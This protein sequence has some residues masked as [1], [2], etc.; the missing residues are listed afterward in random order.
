MESDWHS[1]KLGDLVDIKHGFALKSENFC[2]E[3][4]NDIL[5]TPGHKDA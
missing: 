5:L 4:T 2:D 3:P 1:F